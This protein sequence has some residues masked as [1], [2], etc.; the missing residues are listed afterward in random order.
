MIVASLDRT[1]VVA[2]AVPLSSK[3]RLFGKWPAIAEFRALAAD[4]AIRQNELGDADVELGD[5]EENPRQPQASA[6]CKLLPVPHC[7]T[8]IERSPSEF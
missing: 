2:V 3:N 6:P 5:E 1:A 8:K 4:L 7:G